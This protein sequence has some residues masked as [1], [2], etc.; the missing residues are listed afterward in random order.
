M[1]LFVGFILNRGRYMLL[2]I[3]QSVFFV[4]IIHSFSDY[5]YIGIQYRHNVV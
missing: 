4:F 1:D 3:K 5:T 2:C